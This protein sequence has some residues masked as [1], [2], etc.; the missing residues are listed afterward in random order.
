M[1]KSGVVESIGTKE[2]KTRYGMKPTYSAKIDGE[3][4]KLGFS[5]PP[6]GKGDSISFNYEESTYGMEMDVKSVTMAGAP[7]PTVGGAGAVGAATPSRPA[8]TGGKGVFPIPPL[9]GQRSIVRQSSLTNARELFVATLRSGD[10]ISSLDAA[11]HE[12]VRLAKIFE[13]YSCGDTI[14]EKAAKAK[15]SKVADIPSPS[16]EEMAE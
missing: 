10:V 12:I 13:A 15:A 3:W 14:A 16:A 1:N 5:K 11:A 4:F 7:T 2:V 8:F 6:F 9:D